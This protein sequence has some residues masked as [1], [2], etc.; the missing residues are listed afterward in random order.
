MN[1]GKRIQKLEFRIQ[2]KEPGTVHESML[3]R[4]F[5]HLSSI[6]TSGFSLSYFTALKN[7]RIAAMFFAFPEPSSGGS[8]VFASGLA[9]P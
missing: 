2:N 6:L 7:A 4:V 3:C 5:F 8:V 9:N 1:C